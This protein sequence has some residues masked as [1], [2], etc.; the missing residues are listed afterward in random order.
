MENTPRILLLLLYIGLL[1][2][3]YLQNIVLLNIVY[4]FPYRLSRTTIFI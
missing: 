1:L 3:L 2:F 4:R